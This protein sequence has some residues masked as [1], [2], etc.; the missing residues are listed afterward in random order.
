MQCDLLFY[1]FYSFVFVFFPIISPGYTEM[2]LRGQKH[3]IFFYSSGFFFYSDEYIE[4]NTREAGNS[5][6][7]DVFN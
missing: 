3:C 1:L 5:M 2:H 4:V 7:T 6:K